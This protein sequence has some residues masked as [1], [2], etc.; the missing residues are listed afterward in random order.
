MR[1]SVLTGF[2]Q[3]PQEMDVDLGKILPQEVRIRTAAAGICH[4][5]RFGQTGGNP[6]LGL[7]VVL[8]HE[9]AGVVLEVGS[10]VASVQPGDHVV[11]APAGSCGT[12]AWCSRGLPQHCTNLV[13]VRPDGQGSRL[14]MDGE[15]V[16]QFVGIGAFAEEMLVRESSIAKVPSA[17]PLDVAALL[18]CAVIT[19]LGAIRHTAGVRL[20]ETVAVIGCGGVGL[21]AIQGAALAGAT[22]IIGIDRVPAKLET[23]RAFGATDVVDATSEDAVQAVLDLTGGVDHAIEVVGAPATIAQAFAMLGTRGTATVVGLARAGDTVEI[24]TS[25]FLSEKRIQGSRLG[26]TQLRVDVPLYAEMYLSGRLVLDPLMGRTIDLAG[27]ADALD[28]IDSVA[29]A[30]TVVTF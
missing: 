15:P 19:G 7:P 10:G 11:I 26:G 30:R 6:A 3:R 23:A 13:R 25:A 12:C 9:A 21:S 14:L 4:S 28:E 1:A 2:D 18:G 16:T 17:M 22:R 29:T 5:D 8:G 27:V 20:G 24:P